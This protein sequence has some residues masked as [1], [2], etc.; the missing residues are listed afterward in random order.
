MS[1]IRKIYGERVRVSKKFVGLGRTKPEFKS[2]C[3]I[4]NILNRYAKTGAVNV[5]LASPRYGDFSSVGDYQQA[6]NLM[7]NAE[8]MFSSL[9]ADIRK[10]FSNDPVEFLEFVNN[11]ENREEAI[12]LGLF[13]ADEKVETAQVTSGESSVERAVEG[14]SEKS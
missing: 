10:K 8:S 9:P 7:I 11:E 12:S 1:K 4:Q 2:E 5:N 6:L 13:A 14:N 3:E